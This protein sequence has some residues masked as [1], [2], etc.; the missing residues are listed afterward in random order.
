MAPAS[1]AA[2]RPGRKAEAVGLG[3]LLLAL[4]AVVAV[5]VACVYPLLT[6]YI[7]E[8]GGVYHHTTAVADF[9]G[10]GDLDVLLLN[11]RQE[12]EFTPW[13]VLTVWTN[14]GDGIMTP[15]RLGNEHGQQPGLAATAADLNGDGDVDLVTYSGHQLHVVRNRSSETTAGEV[16]RGLMAVS[17][18]EPVSQ[19]AALAVG[20]VDQDGL[21]DVV[22]AGCCGRMFTLDESF[23]QPNRTAVWTNA[24]EGERVTGEM[25]PVPALDGVPVRAAALGDLDGDGWLDLFAAVPARQP[26]GGGDATDRVLFND[27][28]GGF[29]AEAQLLGSGDSRAVALGDVDGDGDLDALV[30]QQNG[31]V[32]WLNQGSRQGG[33]QGA[34]ARAPQ[35][36]AAG[37]VTA[38][39][40]ADLDGDGDL[41]AVTATASG[42]TIWWNDGNGAFTRD[43]QR[44]PGTKRVGWAVADFNGDGLPDLF[45]A[46][47][48][49]Y[50]TVW[51]NEGSGKFGR[52]P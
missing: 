18:Q 15:R 26:D 14:L 39:Y 19:Y 29:T 44:F 43:R 47:Y 22:I 1:D 41:D 10:D 2:R 40:L 4:L 52:K 28:R 31:A 7:S 30:G 6:I 23:S 50:A 17:S 32:L 5:A 21:L 49:H 45:A 46:S 33:E 13:T 16:F 37:A 3:V 8:T 38:V 12:R 11:L 42:A 36:L 51:L 25:V 24:G 9:D 34:F 35:G 20:D 48:D 27:G